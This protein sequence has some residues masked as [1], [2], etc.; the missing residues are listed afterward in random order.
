MDA[1]LNIVIGVI[2]TALVFGLLAAPLCRGWRL[3]RVAMLGASAAAIV[4]AIGYGIYGWQH[5]LDWEHIRNYPLGMHVFLMT[6]SAALYAVF[7][8]PAALLGA[9][10]FRGLSRRFT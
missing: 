1:P 7:A 5:R 6:F 3:S 10:L 2:M 9:A 4:W 8:F